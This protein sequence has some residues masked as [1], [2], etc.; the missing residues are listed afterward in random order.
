MLILVW[1][2]ETIFCKGWREI[3]IDTFGM[4]NDDTNKEEDVDNAE[5][6]DD[7]TNTAPIWRQ[8]DHF[9]RHHTAIW[10]S[11]ELQYRMKYTNI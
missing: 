4:S 9:S 1:D 11:E 6:I 3:H 5:G 10:D 7:I 2:T 8:V